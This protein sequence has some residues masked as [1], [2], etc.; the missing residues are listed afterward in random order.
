MMQPGSH[1]YGML[2]TIQTVALTDT[3]TCL[4]AE[5]TD[6]ISIGKFDTHACKS[7]RKIVSVFLEKVLEI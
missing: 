1:L 4:H 3:L 6:L 7:A 2:G 5:A